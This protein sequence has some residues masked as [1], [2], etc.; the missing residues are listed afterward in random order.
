[1]EGR[2]TDEITEDTGRNAMQNGP[3]TWGGI[4]F[5]CTGERVKSCDIIRGTESQ[6]SGFNTEEKH[7]VVFGETG[8]VDTI[9][10]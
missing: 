10:C 2:Y 8:N 3:K 5:L 1:M 9:L 4:G 7:L 6:G